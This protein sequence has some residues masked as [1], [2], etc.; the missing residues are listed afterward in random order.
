MITLLKKLA[1]SIGVCGHR[2]ASVEIYLGKAGL[3]K[4]E[5]KKKEFHSLY[6]VKISK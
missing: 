2:N 1:V 6:V 5:Q 4:Q 3:S